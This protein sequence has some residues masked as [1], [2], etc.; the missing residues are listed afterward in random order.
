MGV[1]VCVED[2]LEQL[3]L[4]DDDVLV[5]HQV[6]EQPEL[7]G[8]QVHGPL[9][10]LRSAPCDVEDDPAGGER[11]RCRVTGPSGEGV[12]PRDKHEVG[13]GLHQVVVRTEVEGVG[14]VVLAVLRRQ[15]DHP[16]GLI[17]DPEPFE[18]LVAGEPGQH[19]VEHNGIEG[20]YRAGL[21]RCRAVVRRLYGEAVCAKP[22]GQ[23]PGQANFI[24]DEQ[25]SHRPTS[26][27][28]SARPATRWCVRSQPSLST[29]AACWRRLVS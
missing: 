25:H 8:G 27:V 18:D 13:E 2:P 16:R 29:A 1:G 9:T 12:Q 4:A 19:D 20:R 14:E 10:D 7:S 23:R 5:A 3:Q 11:L 22:A 6:L 28:Q 15:H 26:F 21:E 24:V 17:A